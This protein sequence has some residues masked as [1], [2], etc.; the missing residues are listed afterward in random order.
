MIDGQCAGRRGDAGVL[1][2]YGLKLLP[3]SQQRANVGRVNNI[4]AVLGEPGIS[5]TYNGRPKQKFTYD[6]AAANADEQNAIVVAVIDALYK[7][8]KPRGAGQK[9]AA[10][11]EMNGAVVQIDASFDESKAAAARDEAFAYP[12]MF[13]RRSS[14]RSC[15]PNSICWRSAIATRW[16][17]GSMCSGTG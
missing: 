1:A 11:S 13:A 15:R 9:V 3:P 12:S 5:V 8:E 16:W 10:R 17:T 14:R 7:Y 6:P 4:L 2:L